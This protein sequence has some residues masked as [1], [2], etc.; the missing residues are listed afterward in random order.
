MV[1]CASCKNKT[2]L[3]RCAS[4]ALPGLSLCGRHAKMKTP[5]L[6]GVVNG[7]DKKAIL[8]S[9]IWKGYFIRKMLKLAGPGVL[10]R[11]KCVN[12]E[13]ILTFESIR[14][15]DVFHY[16]GFEENG[17]IYGFDVETILNMFKRNL[18]PANPYTRQPISIDDRKRLREIYSYRIRNK[19]QK[20][21]DINGLTSMENHV[22]SK[23]VHICQI[24]EENGFNGV[25]PNLFLDL[26]RAQLFVLLTMIYNDMKTWAAE[27]SSIKSKRFLHVFWIQNIL[28]KFSAVTGKLE[29][30]FLVSSILLSI[31]YDSIQPYNVC[32]IIMSALYRL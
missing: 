27:H 6:W 14:S 26:N 10:N 12:E 4:N 30:S 15:V 5:R 11:T 24:A 13:E 9:K 31:L 18:L 16:F 3:D 1:L 32:F 23:W 19:I 8:I 29:Y 20:L 21:H 28:K 2:S 17:K 22:E 7:L 25:S